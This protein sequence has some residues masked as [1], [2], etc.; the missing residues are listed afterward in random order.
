MAK[1]PRTFG[2]TVTKGF[3]QAPLSPKPLPDGQSRRGSCNPTATSIYA[4]TVFSVE[5]EDD[6]DYEQE[7]LNDQQWILQ[8]KKIGLS[9]QTKRS[10]RRVN[11][12]ESKRHN[13]S[14]FL[15]ACGPCPAYTS[16]FT[17]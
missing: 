1:P 5:A 3:Y 12:T 7:P 4:S 9:R 2:K 14:S 13:V 8:R 10:L 6:E 17:M 11:Q 16:T 15:K